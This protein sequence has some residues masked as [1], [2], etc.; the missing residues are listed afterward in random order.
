MGYTV[1]ERLWIDGRRAISDR[2]N[3]RLVHW[4]ISRNAESENKG[5]HG[6][7]RDRLS[8]EVKPGERYDLVVESHGSG[9]TTDD[10]ALFRSFFVLFKKKK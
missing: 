9:S 7:R 3:S 10:V 6:C 5:L 4:S 1:A 2:P 8:L